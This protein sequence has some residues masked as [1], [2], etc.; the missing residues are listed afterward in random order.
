MADRLNLVFKGLICTKE[1]AQGNLGPQVIL[2]L[3]FI[4]MELHVNLLVHR[5]W[6]CLLEFWKICGP[7]FLSI[8]P[9]GPTT[10]IQRHILLFPQLNMKI[11]SILENFF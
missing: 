11:H 5:I 2:E 1:K 6:K 4:I 7:M 8:H 10:Y 3:W 9:V